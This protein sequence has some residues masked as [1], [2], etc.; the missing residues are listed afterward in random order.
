MAHT[1][2]FTIINRRCIKMKAKRISS[3]QYAKEWAKAG[4]PKRGPHK[5][6]VHKK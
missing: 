5:S 1:K 3:F 2:L 6:F 4:F